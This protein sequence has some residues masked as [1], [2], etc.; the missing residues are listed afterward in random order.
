MTTTL[1]TTATG[2]GYH[3]HDVDIDDTFDFL[4]TDDTENGSPLERLATLGDALSWFVER[5]VIHAEGA[6]RLDRQAGSD[7]GAAARD[8]ARIHAVRAALREVTDALVEHRQASTG[9]LD[10]VNRA[11][12]ARQVIEL[13]PSSD[14]CVAVDHRHVGDPIDDALARLCDPLVT[15]LTGGNPERIKICDNDRCRWVFYD[16]SRTGRRRWCDMSTCGNRAKAARHRAKSRAG[17]PADGAEAPAG[18]VVSV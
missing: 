5:G 3:A 11:L 7:A 13:V 1:S 4:N 10:T 8:L 2:R 6:H 14:G 17:A 15:E 9:A 18:E 16:T 12:H